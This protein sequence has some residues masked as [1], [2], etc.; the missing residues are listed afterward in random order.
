METKHK[1]KCSRIIY[2][3]E[4]NKESRELGQ[5]QNV[6]LDESRQ[7]RNDPRREGHQALSSKNENKQM[8]E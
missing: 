5:N 6:S 7:L 1:T 3:L 8:K 2:K 4:F